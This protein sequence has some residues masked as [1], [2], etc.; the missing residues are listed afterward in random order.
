MGSPSAPTAARSSGRTVPSRTNRSSRRSTAWWPA[1]RY[2]VTFDWAA[3]QQFGFNG[4][5]ASGWMVSFGSAPSQSTGNLV[6]GNHGFSGWQQ[7]TF[8]F[9]ADG[10][11]DTLSFLSTGIGGAALPPF[12]LLDGV[13]LTARAGTVYLG[14][15]GPRLRPSRLRGLPQTPHGDLDRLSAGLS[16]RNDK[17]PVRGRLE[18][19][20]RLRMAEYGARS[21]AGT[22]SWPHT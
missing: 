9:I 1:H 16:S 6:I 21:L 15:D 12:S 20:W 4:P 8:D 14:D 19:L 10:T 5:T 17:P 18:R 3:A 7:S 2:A 13:S 22:L 11:S